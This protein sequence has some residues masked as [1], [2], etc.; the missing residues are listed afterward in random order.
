MPESAI[1]H[2]SDT[3]QLKFGLS[4]DTA[5]LGYGWWTW[6][7]PGLTLVLILVCVNLLGDAL[8]ASVNPG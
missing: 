1:A 5:T 7:L 6:V 2:V 3:V 8:D 4:Q